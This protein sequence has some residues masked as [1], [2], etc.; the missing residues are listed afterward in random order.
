MITTV[1]SS[2]WAH[3]ARALSRRIERLALE[4]KANSGVS[5]NFTAEAPDNYPALLAAWERSKVTGTLDIWNGASEDAIYP[6]E[7]NM[8]F[9][10]WHD[11]GH[12]AHGLSF[13]PEDERELQERYHIWELRNLGLDAAGLPMRLYVADTIGQIEYIQAHHVFPADQAAFARTYVID[14]PRALETVF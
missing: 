13:T 8:K 9:R 1:S 6:A 14:K 4:A 12:I 11:M 2:E 7:I 3:A 10:F 5:P